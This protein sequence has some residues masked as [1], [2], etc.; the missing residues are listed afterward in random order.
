MRDL[1]LIFVSYKTNHAE[2]ESLSSCLARLDKSIGYAVV[3]NKYT[4]GEPIDSLEKDAD[5][6]MRLSSN[7]GYG[8]AINR[9]SKGVNSKWIAAINTDIIWGKGCFEDLATWLNNNQGVAIAVPQ[10]LD[11]KGKLQMLCKKDPSVLALISR[12]F[13]PHRLKPRFLKRY[14]KSYTYGSYDYHEVFEACY[15]S[16]CCMIINRAIFEYVG[17]FDERFFLYLEDADLTR[18]MRRHGR[19]IHLPISSIVHTWGRGNYKSMRL[20]FVNIISTVTY[21]RKWGIKVY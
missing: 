8:A 17:G 16:G 11:Q 14:D 21:F 2:V 19:C 12:R 1:T 4:P 13:L 18:S 7:V 3:V 10:I 20:A 5:A 15:L 9:I 6:F